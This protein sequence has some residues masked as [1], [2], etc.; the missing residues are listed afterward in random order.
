[1]SKRQ[2]SGSE[3]DGGYSDDSKARRRLDF[4]E[5]AG[6]SGMPPGNEGGGADSNAKGGANG[7]GDSG[8]GVTDNDPLTHQKF[9]GSIIRKVT[10]GGKSVDESLVN[11]NVMWLPMETFM[12]QIFNEETFATLQSN[13]KNAASGGTGERIIGSQFFMFT[14]PIRCKISK[15]LMTQRSLTTGAT[16]VSALDFSQ[17]GVLMIYDS[18]KAL[19][20]HTWLLQPNGERV[21]ATESIRWPLPDYYNINNLTNP[22]IIT[23]NGSKYW[24]KGCEA[25]PLTNTP[26]A[27]FDCEQARIW[28]PRRMR[29]SNH[30]PSNDNRHGLIPDTTNTYYYAVAS[31]Q[32]QDTNEQ[33]AERVEGEGYAVKGLLDEAEHIK[34]LG[35]GETY[36]WTLENTFKNRIIALDDVRAQCRAIYDDDDNFVAVRC[37]DK[38]YIARA[39]H[40]KWVHTDNVNQS[41]L[42]TLS[43]LDRKIKPTGNKLLFMPSLKDPVG[44]ELLPT[45]VTFTFEW[46][47]DVAIISDYNG[48]GSLRMARHRVSPGWGSV[49]TRAAQ[50]GTTRTNLYTRMLWK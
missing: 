27:N 40:S 5:D 36:E 46:E 4:G 20:G 10:L 3:S 49:N 31:I 48:N 39:D 14:S 28:I 22:G 15:V 45:G 30:L 24:L 44:G 11:G 33:M 41:M 12:G 21:N 37:W 2:H 25:G 50:G 32:P 23:P 19:D 38:P 35:V 47:V 9:K 8:S 16:P 42:S 13:Y 17:S 26:I 34:S 1:M 29:P 18:Q 43:L 7:V 6:G